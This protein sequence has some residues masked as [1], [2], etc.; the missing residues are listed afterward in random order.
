[1]P[2]HMHET[3]SLSLC[4]RTVGIYTCTMVLLRK[5]QVSFVYHV[6]S[7]RVGMHGH[8]VVVHYC[9]GVYSIVQGCMILPN[10][11]CSVVLHYCPGVAGWQ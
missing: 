1:M 5:L 4:V 10:W 7:N 11:G 3:R 8:F 2:K 6:E 9:T